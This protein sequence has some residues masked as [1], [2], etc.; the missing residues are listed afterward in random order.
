[1]KTLS[2]T[3]VALGFGL[4]AALLTGASQTAWAQSDWTGTWENKGQYKKIELIQSGKFVYGEIDDKSFLQATVSSDGLTLRGYVEAADPRQDGYFE[5][6]KGDPARR[7]GS[8]IAKDPA[9]FTGAVWFT[10]DYKALKRWPVGTRPGDTGIYARFTDEARPDIE[11]LF[12]RRPNPNRPA[13][14]PTRANFIASVPEPEGRAW[15]SYRTTDQMT[16][17]QEEFQRGLEANRREITAQR[18]ERAAVR[19][20]VKTARRA[21]IDNMNATARRVTPNR[22]YNANL[23]NLPASTYGTDFRPTMLTIGLNDITTESSLDSVVTL[24]TE[25]DAEVFGAVFASA[26]CEWSN[27]SVKTKMEPINGTSTSIFSATRSDPVDISGVRV[28]GT[29]MNV[30]GTPVKYNIRDCYDKPSARIKLEVSYTLWEKD[31]TILTDDSTGTIGFSVYLEDMPHTK[32]EES[33]S[34]AIGPLEIRGTFDTDTYEKDPYWNAFY[35]PEEDVEN[36]SPETFIILS[37]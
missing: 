9:N 2:G 28:R 6:T 24:F 26:V 21:R 16:A 7:I 8:E 23:A 27:G 33:S 11:S 18:E 36:L 13:G 1:M 15:L 25:G 30:P 10:Q 32:G 19:R 12:N 3:R 37:D 31:N 4:A 34:V 17:N 20:E 14:R 22:N 29:A 35:D 5:F